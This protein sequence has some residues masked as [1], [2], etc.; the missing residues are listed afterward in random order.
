MSISRREEVLQ[1][2]AELFAE[3]GFHAVGMRAI[4]DAVGVRGSSL[5]HYFPSKVDLLHAIAVD[6]TRTFIES[7]LEDLSPSPD[8]AARVRKMM[9]DHV[10]Y[11]HEHRMEEAVGLRE[12][13]ELR[14]HKPEAYTELQTLRRTYQNELE[15]LITEGRDKGEF[16]CDDPHITTLAILGMV[17][18]INDWYRPHRDGPIEKIADIYSSLI[19]ER[20]LGK[21][22]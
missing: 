18:T 20:M 22:L 4:A 1:A 16:S 7:Q 14:K 10:V 13:Q 21:T 5:Y 8:Y 19:V 6:S 17:N 11:F 15:R 9:F 3:Q 12:L 2:A